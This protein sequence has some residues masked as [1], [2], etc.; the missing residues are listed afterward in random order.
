MFGQGFENCAVNGS[1]IIVKYEFDDDELDNIEINTSAY[2]TIDGFEFDG[3]VGSV[4]E[5]EYTQGA[6][7]PDVRYWVAKAARPSRS[8]M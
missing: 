4:G 2:P 3:T 8:T 5:W 7:D 6:G 1:P